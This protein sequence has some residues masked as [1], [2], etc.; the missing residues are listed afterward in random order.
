[1]HHV[2]TIQSSLAFIDQYSFWAYAI[3]PFG[4]ATEGDLTLLFSGI[5]A[6]LGS[7]NLLF[8]LPLAL[9]GAAGKSLIGYYIGQCLN[10]KYPEHKFLKFVERRVLEYLPHVKEKPFW[11]LLVSKFLYGFF[12]INYFVLFF[13]GYIK[14]NFRKYFLYEMISSFIW[15]ISVISL[16]YV[17]SF[18]ALQLSHDIRNF[19]IIIGIFLAL[20]FCAEKVF[21]LIV[22]WFE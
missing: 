5:F 11:S 12:A 18:A 17:F 1:M 22:E 9:A 4:V 15:I 16:G 2:I 6:H 14:A 13:L 19:L 20:F 3:I 7:L 21:S 10:K 8:V